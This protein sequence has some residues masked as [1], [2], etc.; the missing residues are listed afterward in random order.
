MA[1]NCHSVR[2]AENPSITVQL[3]ASVKWNETEKKNRG[4][5]KLWEIRKKTK[6]VVHLEASEQTLAQHPA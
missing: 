5:Q 2:P 1:L 4:A 6:S 3:G